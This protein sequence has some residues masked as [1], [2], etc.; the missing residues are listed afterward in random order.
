V[1][2]IKKMMVHNTYM[3]WWFDFYGECGV[4]E[5]REKDVFHQVMRQCSVDKNKQLYA[6]TLAHE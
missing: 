6:R 5:K 3:T 2:V 1:L 4:R